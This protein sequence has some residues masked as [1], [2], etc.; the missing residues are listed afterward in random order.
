VHGGIGI[1]LDVHSGS[2]QL[3][4]PTEWKEGIMARSR[5]YGFTGDALIATSLLSA[6][7]AASV[8]NLAHLRAEQ[9]EHNQ[10]EWDWRSAAEYWKSRA[11][12]AERALAEAEADLDELD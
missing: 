1:S 2:R 11:L 10:R 12:R 9:N 8:S 6:A 7:V 5:D 3:D 4:G